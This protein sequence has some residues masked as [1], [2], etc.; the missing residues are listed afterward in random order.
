MKSCE[1]HEQDRSL[2]I[3]QSVAR[4]LG[5]AIL[6]GEYL[7]GHVLGGEIGASEALRVSRTA[8]REGIRLLTAKGLLESRPKAGTHVTPR[9]RWNMLDPDLLAW[10]FLSGRP[11]PRFVRELFEL[12]GLI[13]PPAAA[14]AAARRTDDHVR[15]LRAALDIMREEGLATAEG[16]AADQR[17]H[18]TIL[19]AADN[20]LLASLSSSVGSAV[21]W[22]T[23]FK[24]ERSI[25]PRPSFADHLA[26]FDG[27]AAADT[28]RARAAMEEL[29]RLALEDMGIT[30][31]PEAGAANASP[32]P[33]AELKGVQRVQE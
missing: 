2:R 26:V 6:S 14:M 23:R 32:N 12:R 5:I 18:S 21:T 13:E 27:I 15:Q 20:E 16:R 29:L 31:G 10:M 11:D 22:T 9:S 19:E 1:H 33:G 25:D 7:P 17:F 28:V 4:Q 3:H 30:G 8:Y 24:Q